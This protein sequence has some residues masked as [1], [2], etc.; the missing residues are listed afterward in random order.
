MD[1]IVSPFDVELGEL[2]CALESM[3]EII[4]EGEGVRAILLT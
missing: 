4:D 3:D 1:I 2:L